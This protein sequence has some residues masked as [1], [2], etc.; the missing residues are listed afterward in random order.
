[1]QTVKKRAAH[2]RP[3]NRAALPGSRDRN[4]AACTGDDSDLLNVLLAA[5]FKGR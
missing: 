3:G 4:P 1:M 5:G 2:P